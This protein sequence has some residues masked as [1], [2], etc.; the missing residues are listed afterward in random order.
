VNSVDFVKFGKN[1]KQKDRPTVTEVTNPKISQSP[2]V[3]KNSSDLD[4]TKYSELFKEGLGKLKEFKASISLKEGF[5]PK[6]CKPRPVPLSQ[7]GKVETEIQRLIDTGILSPIQYSDWATPIV[8]VPKPD[9]TVRI[10]GDYSVT[11][12]PELH[13]EY[14]PVPRAEDVFSDL[15]GCDT[16]SK[17][18]L[19]DAF[20]QLELEEVSK[21]ILT[22]T[23]HK[24]LFVWNRMPL[25]LASSPGIFQKRIEQVLSGISKT[26]VFY[27]DILVAGKG[28]QNHNEHLDKVLTRLQDKGLRLKQSKCTINRKEIKYLGFLINGEGLHNLP[29]IVSAIQDA[30]APEDIT[31]LRSF[32]GFINQY[33]KFISHCATILAPLSRLLQKGVKWEWDQSCNDAFVKIK[34]KFLTSGVLV[35]Y[36]STLPLKLVC[37]GSPYGVGAALFHVYP[38]G[39][40]RPIGFGSRVLT[41]SEQNYAQFDREAL[42]IVYGVKKFHHFLYGQHFQLC[43]DHQ[44]LTWVFGSKKGIPTTAAARVQRWAVFLAGYDFT[45][46]HIKGKLNTIADSLSRLPL[47]DNTVSK[48]ESDI[49]V[50]RV[51]VQQIGVLPILPEQLKYETM[52]DAEMLS[53]LNFAKRGWPT[54]APPGLMPYYVRRS[55][56]SCDNDCLFWGLRVIIPTKLRPQVLQELHIGHVGIVKMKALGRSHVWWPGLDAAIEELVK[57]CESC[58]INRDET[59]KGPKHVWEFPAQAWERLHADFAGPFLG[60]MFLL[61]IDAHSKWPEII[62]MSS[63]TSA[64]TICELRKIFSNKGLPKVFVTDN[65]PQWMSAEFESFLHTN[66]VLHITGA[67]YH[68]ETNGAAENLVKTFKRSLKA[69]KATGIPVDVALEQFLLAYRTTPHATTNVTPAKLLGRELR[70]RLDLLRPELLKERVFRSQQKSIVSTQHRVDTPLQPGTSVWARDFRPNGRNWQR[71]LVAS[72]NHRS[73]VVQLPNGS[74]CRRHQDQLR[75]A[76]PYYSPLEQAGSVVSPSLRRQPQR[77]S[78]FPPTVADSPPSSPLQPGLLNLDGPE[79]SVLPAATALMTSASRPAAGRRQVEEPDVGLRRSQRDRR[80]PPKFDL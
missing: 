22:I 47:P 27:D 53:V 12:N 75:A 31:Q 59:P 58:Q 13:I 18:D 52:H 45:I 6:Y 80:P 1:L 24:G 69:S 51:F 54:T 60:K 20:L 67:P 29:E 14:F 26:K 77:E 48:I 7:R 35:H 66:G 50:A 32:L 73:Y 55:E 71:A 68:P 76:E 62:D 17:V 74:T 38:S 49:S 63:T 41:K 2:I 16:F 8:V 65:G 44:A 4:L 79:V 56:I 42:S 72:R 11:V 28:T 78:I 3:T 30:P 37:D 9:G 34:K 5:H 21:P 36:D 15:A 46:S 39:E 19:S 61:V 23:T 33:S 57:H 70:T 64:K 43:T 40:E 10:V 25:G